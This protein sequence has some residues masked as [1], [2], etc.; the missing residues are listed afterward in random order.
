MKKYAE[1]KNIE[2]I[3]LNKILSPNGFLD[4]KYT[5]DG[6]HLN[7]D[8]YVLWAKEIINYFED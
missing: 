7:G 6:I 1:D 2:F 3:D 4:N 8:A 5:T